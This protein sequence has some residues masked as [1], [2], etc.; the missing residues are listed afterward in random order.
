MGS[1][2]QCKH[3]LSHP[4]TPPPR[5]H[6]AFLPIQAKIIRYLKYRWEAKRGYSESLLG[7]SQILCNER[8]G[9]SIY[10][11]QVE[12]ISQE[13]YEFNG[14]FPTDQSQ[15]Y[16]GAGWKCRL[17]SGNFS[18]YIHRSICLWRQTLHQGPQNSKGGTTLTQVEVKNSKFILVFQFI[19][20]SESGKDRKQ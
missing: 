11:H 18:V 3:T 20:D 1:I 15:G 6:S 7:P 14:R 17:L 19:K 8:S 16:N 4:F 5:V 13:R 9:A 12:N 10:Q 2:S